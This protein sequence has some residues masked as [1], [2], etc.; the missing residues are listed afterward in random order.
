[1]LTLLI[2]FNSR[3]KHTTRLNPVTLKKNFSSNFLIAHSG[4]APNIRKS[5]MGA[6]IHE[7]LASIISCILGSAL[8]SAHTNDC[9]KI[10]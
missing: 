8:D 3:P 9:K 2:I 6:D 10:T 5:P 4:L 1:M 7:C